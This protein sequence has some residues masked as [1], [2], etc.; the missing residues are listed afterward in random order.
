MSA[1]PALRVRASLQRAGV[2]LPA[3]PDGDLFA[4]GLDSLR[5]AIAVLELEREFSI[6][7]KPP[8]PLERVFRSTASVCAWVEEQRRA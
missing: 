5:I 3:S 8:Q 6:R 2:V 4:L 7:L 1:D